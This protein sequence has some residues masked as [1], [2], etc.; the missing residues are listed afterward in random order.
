MRVTVEKSQVFGKVQAP[1]SKSYA[2]RKIIASFLSGNYA[3]IKGVGNSSDVRH[4]IGCIK[5]LGANV[6]YDG[7][8]LF[9]DGCETVKE[10]TVDCGESATLLRILFPVVAA[11][12]IKTKFICL[13][14]L[15]SRPHDEIFKCL[16]GHGVKIDEK[17]PTV[18]GRLDGGEYIIDVTRSSQ[19]LSGLL[20][21]LPLIGNGAVIRTNGSP[22]SAYYV[23]MTISVMANYGV[24]I[25]NKD[26]FYFLSGKTKYVAPTMSTIEGDWSGA[27]F[28]L[29]LGAIA[30][31]VTVCG[32][33]P[34]IEHGDKKIVDY[35]KLFG[36]NVEVEKDGVT[37]GKSNLRACEVDCIDT[38]DLVPV[39]AALAAFAEGESVIKNV[40]RLKF[41]ETD[42]VS[43]IV[44]IM[45]SVGVTCNFDNKNLIIKG[46][47]VSH[48]NFGCIN[49]H[50]MIMLETLLAAGA[51][52]A[53]AIEGAEAV[54]KSYPEFF[55]HFKSV[56]GKI[57]VDV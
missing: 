55:G 28:Y 43:A 33:D 23:A 11:L 50:R 16:A 32:L 13:G 22:V 24:N 40:E 38:P 29:A 47:K 35:L 56:G 52:G 26:D 1:P 4:C 12:G 25:E 54:G 46:G 17:N 9:I 44:A 10:A 30:G 31:R 20:F 37:V 2:I 48:T 42:R 21:A 53:S 18:E 49:D 36:A 51:D 5:S 14:S 8:N 3:E 45:N 39:V 27:A 34:S 15:F 41:K 57:N 6:R 19:F 7:E